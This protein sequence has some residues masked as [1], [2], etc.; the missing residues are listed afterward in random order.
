MADLTD[1]T[2]SLPSFEDRHVN[3]E[4][5]TVADY[6]RLWSGGVA[7]QGT[8]TGNPSTLYYIRENPIT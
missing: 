2:S 3:V 1:F 7:G 6:D 4:F 8:F 5:V